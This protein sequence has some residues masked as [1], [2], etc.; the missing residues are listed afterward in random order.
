M[1]GDAR[2]CDAGFLGADRGPCV[3]AVEPDG[4]VGEAGVE[5]GGESRQHRRIVQRHAAAQRLHRDQP[6]EGAAV[7]Q[8]KAERPGD[9]GGDGALA[10]RRRAVDGDHRHRGQ[11]GH[12]DVLAPAGCAI[13]ANSAK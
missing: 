9:P 10:R 12:A 7:E 11:T 3:L 1:D 6:V 5:L 13:R 4:A 2:G 8:V